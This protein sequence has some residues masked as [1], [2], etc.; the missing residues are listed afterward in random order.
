MIIYKFFPRRVYKL[1]LKAFAFAGPTGDCAL[2]EREG[3]VWLC[4][5][6]HPLTAGAA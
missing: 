6:S 3:C 1:L 2:F 5:S 4:P